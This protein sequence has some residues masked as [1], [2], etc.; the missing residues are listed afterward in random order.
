[1]PVVKGRGEWDPLS[2]ITKNFMESYAIHFD[3]NGTSNLTQ[4]VPVIG[5]GHMVSRACLVVHDITYDD[6]KKD[7]I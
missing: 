2:E 5:V 1:M 7:V 4:M 3:I 6:I